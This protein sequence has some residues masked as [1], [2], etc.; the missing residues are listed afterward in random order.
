MAIDRCRSCFTDAA[1]TVAQREDKASREAAEPLRVSKART[2]MLGSMMQR[3][4]AGGRILT[5][6]S[7][8]GEDNS[9]GWQDVRHKAAEQMVAVRELLGR[10]W[11]AA[12]RALYLRRQL[13]G[14]R[15]GVLLLAGASWL[16]IHSARASREPAELHRKELCGTRSSRCF[17]IHA[18][19]AS[20]R[21]GRAARRTQLR[22]CAHFGPS[23]RLLL[24]TKLNRI[25]PGGWRRAQA[26][27][28]KSRKIH[29]KR[30]S[31]EVVA[32]PR[33]QADP[34]RFRLSDTALVH[35]L[36]LMLRRPQVEPTQTTLPGAGAIIRP[37]RQ[38]QSSYFKNFAVR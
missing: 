19:R 21:D 10:V 15:T 22:K 17:A 33:A 5:E 27:G 6:E 36:P 23:E 11:I 14:A 20:S 29:G 35:C 18:Q 25:A 12:T 4:P 24:T 16:A 13:S 32:P 3:L 34:I 31:V 2:E 1:V 28:A 38:R 9:A 26:E 37:R 8:D 30:S 7:A